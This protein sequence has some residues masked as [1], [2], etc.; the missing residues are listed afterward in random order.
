MKYPALTV[1][2]IIRYQKGIVLTS[3]LFTIV[4]IPSH[5]LSLGLLAFYS[6]LLV[7]Y[8]TLMGGY[9]WYRTRNLWVITGAHMLED[10][11]STIVYSLLN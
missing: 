6:I 10:S 1:D 9:V 8:S 3:L 7:F 2:V 4:H 11:T 5:V